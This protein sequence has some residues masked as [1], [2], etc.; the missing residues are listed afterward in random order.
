MLC[1]FLRGEEGL[2][3]AVQCISPGIPSW[4]QINHAAFLLYKG[5]S[6]SPTPWQT[7]PLSV[8]EILSTSLRAT[9]FFFPS[10]YLHMSF[11][12]LRTPFPLTSA[13]SFQTL[14]F[15]L[16]VP[17]S[18]KL[19]LVSKVLGL[20]W[21][22]EFTL[23]YKLHFIIIACFLVCPLCQVMYFLRARTVSGTCLLLAHSI[24][25][26]HSMRA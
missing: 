3:L 24:G 20:L 17:F 2:A 15:S 7:S 6:D 12:L 1:K 25:I 10:G 26:L 8:L 23:N 13:H 21:P 4:D 5:R 18:G 9:Y 16:S 19:S 22:P 11:H 14:N